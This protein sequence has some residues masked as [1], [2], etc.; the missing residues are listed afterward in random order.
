[1]EIKSSISAKKTGLPKDIVWLEYTSTYDSVS[2]W[3]LLRNG[4]N[5]SA[6]IVCLHGHGSQGDQ[7]YTSEHIHIRNYWLA[8]FVELGMGIIT[9]NLR[10]NAWMSPAALHDMSEL[11]QYLRGEYA[12]ER[13]IFASGSMGGTSNLIYA[14]HR[15]QEVFAVVALGAATDMTTYY[16]WCRQQ[17][18]ATCQEIADAIQDSYGGEPAEVPD[19]YAANSV[20]EHCHNLTMPVFLAHGQSD[21]FMPIQH[22][23]ILAEKMKDVESFAFREIPHGDHDSPLPLMKEGLRRV[24]TK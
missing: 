3:A 13:F 24:S 9:P 19:T 14:I 18:E 7:L 4:T 8:A 2:D 21:Q 6:W 22:A 10:N 5:P 16:Q 15:P 20:L 23:R 1:M 17:A 12:A 11:L